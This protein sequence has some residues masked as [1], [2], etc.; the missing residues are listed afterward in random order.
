MDDDDEDDSSGRV[1]GGENE[2]GRARLSSFPRL[3]LKS[4]NS[5]ERLLFW[6]RRHRVAVTKVDA[7]VFL[8]TEDLFLPS[9][10]EN[11]A[12]VSAIAWDSVAPCDS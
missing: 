8:G 4:T 2:H 6:D 11:R 5:R 3:W 12:V 10:S 1:G 7:S 9:V